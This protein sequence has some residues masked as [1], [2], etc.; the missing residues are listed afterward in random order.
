MKA[1]ST[2]PFG[3]PK[4]AQ[5]VTLPMIINGRI[6]SPGDVDVFAVSCHAGEHVV[7]EVYARR[8]NSPLDSWLRVTD[9][10]GKQLAFN[11]DYEDKGAGLLTQNAD[12]YLTFT[13][14]ADGIYY[15]HLG[16]AQGKGG[17]EYSYRLRISAPMPDFALYATPSGINGR[18]G[19]SVPRDG[20]G[21]AQGR[22]FGRDFAGAQGCVDGVCP[23]RRKNSGGSG[24]GACD[25]YF[26]AN[27]RLR[28][29]K[30]RHAPRLGRTR[31][32]RKTRNRPP[33]PV[34]AD[35][36]IQAFMYHHLVPA[37]ELIA[38][39]A[40]QPGRTPVTTVNPPR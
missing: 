10:T 12:S 16:D 32:D 38:L 20:P 17:P 13:A 35:D 37:H 11:D 7:A 28:E 3:T 1:E 27:P 40:A 36:M 34:P 21:C 4:Q 14:P 2:I 19:A 8:L 22:L 30:S 24:Q 26:S 5:P 6:D 33:G 23:G 15:I 25:H 31:Y 9:A 18:P 39:V 29:D